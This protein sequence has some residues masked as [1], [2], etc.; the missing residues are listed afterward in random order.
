MEFSWTTRAAIANQMAYTLDFGSV[1]IEDSLS[2]FPK[3]GR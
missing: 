2:W 1:S 3:A